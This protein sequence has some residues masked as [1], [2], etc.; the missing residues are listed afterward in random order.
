MLVVA[1]DIEGRAWHDLIERLTSL[2]V[3]DIAVVE[4]G[5]VASRR[6]GGDHIGP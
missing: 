5:R 4:G 2:A 3:G 6:S 1:L